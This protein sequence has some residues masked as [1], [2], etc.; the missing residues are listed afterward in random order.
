MTGANAPAVDSKT[1][2]LLEVRDLFYIHW[3]WRAIVSLRPRE[4]R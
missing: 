1:T 2:K 4:T 3:V